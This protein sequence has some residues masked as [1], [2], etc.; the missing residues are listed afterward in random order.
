MHIFTTL[1]HI[2][3]FKLSFYFKSKKPSQE[4]YTHMLDICVREGRGVEGGDYKK[5][6]TGLRLNK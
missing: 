2:S 3:P 4:T 6:T 1:F 5:K